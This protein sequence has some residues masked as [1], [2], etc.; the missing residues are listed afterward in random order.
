MKEKD[1]LNYFFKYVSACEMCG[2]DIV[3]HQ[4]LGQ[5]LNQSQGFN[6]RN[7]TGISTSVMQCNVCKLIYSN[8]MPI[9][10]NIQDHYGIPPERYWSPD[11][12][13]LNPNYFGEEITKTK[14]LINF[15]EG[16]TALD[17]GA[18]IGKGMLAMET[19]G[20]DVYGIEPSESFYQKAIDDMRIQKNKLRLGGI[21]NV[22]YPNN[23]FDFITFGAVLEHLFYPGKSIE[24]SLSWL[25]PGGIIHIE[26]PST[27]YLIAKFINLYF[28]L[29]GTTYVTHLSPMHEPFHLYEFHLKSFKQHAL[30]CNSYEIVHFEYYSCAPASFN[31]A[32]RSVLN[33][34]MNFTNTGMQ[35]AIW[36]RKK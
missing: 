19:A 14:K 15:K 32:I 10:A 1:S 4:I 20:F 31:P 7:K 16:M 2:S 36:L 6:P 22:D 25:K 28:R 24:R 21:D 23:F 8:P 29:R 18:G 17:I 26:V 5:R 9:P 11:Y 30:R 35:L 3:F 13:L 33:R 12:F 34:I 27:A